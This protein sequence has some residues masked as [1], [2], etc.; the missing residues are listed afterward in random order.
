MQGKL[1]F[2]VVPDATVETFRLKCRSF[3]PRASAFMTKEE[4]EAKLKEP[5]LPCGEVADKPTNGLTEHLVNDKIA[6]DR[7]KNA[8]IEKP[9]I[10]KDLCSKPEKTLENG[11]PDVKKCLKTA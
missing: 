4:K 7:S 8:A 3:F 5:A 2:S 11:C 6:G 1:V 10:Q 9:L